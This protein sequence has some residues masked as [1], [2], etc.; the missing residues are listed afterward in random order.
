VFKNKGYANF[1]RIIDPLQTCVRHQKYFEILIL[2]V[3]LELQD[4][5]DAKLNWIEP[6][7]LLIRLASLHLP[8]SFKS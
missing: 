6:T 4:L 3:I 8:F 5:N 7:Q 1:E 2:K